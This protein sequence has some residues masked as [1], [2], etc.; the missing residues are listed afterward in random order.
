MA[1]SVERAGRQREKCGA[2]TITKAHT[3]AVYDAVEMMRLASDILLDGSLSEKE[4]HRLSWLL[5]GHARRLSDIIETMEQVEEY[6]PQNPSDLLSIGDEIEA[7]EA[8][9]ASIKRDAE[10]PA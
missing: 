2:A 6:Q 1:D 3:D 5:G 9:L 7:L 10:R 4:C 8:R